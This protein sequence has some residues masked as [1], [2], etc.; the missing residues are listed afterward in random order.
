[1]EKIV[2]ILG[3]MGPAATVDMLQKFV[4]HTP[5]TRDQEHIPILV[6]SIPTIPDRSAS[7]LGDG[8]SPLPAMQEYTQ[9]LVQG[10]AKCILIAC[11][12]AHYWDKALQAQCPVPIFSMLET[13]AEAALNLNAT[14]IGVLASTA[15]IEKGLYRRELE[16]RGLHCIEPDPHNQKAV[17]ESICAL[18]AGDLPKA[19]TLMQHQK[20]LLFQKGAEVIILGCTE[21][22]IILAQEAAET[23]HR[24]IDATLTLVQRAIA[25]Y[26]EK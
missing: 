7:I 9:R 3:G 15:T 6:S 1:M 17:W 26:K 11:N 14:Q 16:K 13:A 2:G 20:E 19:R 10:G 23:P 5:A 18:K 22:P 25:W 24:Y 12:T 8:P 4:D 21:I